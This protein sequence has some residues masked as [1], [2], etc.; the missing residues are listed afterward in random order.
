MMMSNEANIA[1]SRFEKRR[2]SSTSLEDQK[3]EGRNVRSEAN[4]T[5]TLD[6][7]Y[8]VSYVQK[9]IVRSVLFCMTTSTQKELVSGQIYKKTGP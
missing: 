7:L 9:P 4:P 3:R 6:A 8:L 2:A 5:V 1:R